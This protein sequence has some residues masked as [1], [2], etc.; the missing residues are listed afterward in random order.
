MLCGHSRLQVPWSLLFFLLNYG[1]TC[2]LQIRSDS[3]N[4][5]NTSMISLQN[6]YF[7]G[8][9]FYSCF[10]HQSNNKLFHSQSHTSMHNVA[11]KNVFYS[12][13]TGLLFSWRRLLYSLIS[14]LSLFT[15]TIS[16]LYCINSKSFNWY[17]ITFQK[18]ITLIIHETKQAI[19]P[20]STSHHH[21]YKYLCSSYSCL[22]LRWKSCSKSRKIC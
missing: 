14:F 12:T 17:F 13:W 1:F 9:I 7:L 3:M 2:L 8:C 18:K 4:Q 5:Y 16:K 19:L 22:R 6:T 10:L 11:F 21:I 20:P 15:V